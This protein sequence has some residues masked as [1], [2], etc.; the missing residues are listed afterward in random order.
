MLGTLACWRCRER[1]NIKRDNLIAGKAK[2]KKN[3]IKRWGGT[4]MDASTGKRSLLY[5]FIFRKP[6]PESSHSYQTVLFRLRFSRNSSS[7]PKNSKE[8]PHLFVI[9]PRWCSQRL[10]KSITFII[11]FHS[12]PNCRRG[13]PAFGNWFQVTDC[14]QKW[15][16]ACGGEM[17]Y[18]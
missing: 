17:L 7:P 4:G 16:I 1:I 12:L 8:P 6:W 13:E 15:R 14:E 11:T 10:C 18:S 3:K 9:S 2:I 5:I